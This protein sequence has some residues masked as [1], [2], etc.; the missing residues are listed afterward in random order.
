MKIKSKTYQISPCRFTGE[1][2]ATKTINYGRDGVIRVPVK[3]STQ[4]QAERRVSLW[5][6]ADRAA[7]RIESPLPEISGA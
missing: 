3:C 7:A 2:F 5:R 1:Y 6:R 4:E